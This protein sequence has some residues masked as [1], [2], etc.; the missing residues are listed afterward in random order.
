MPFLMEPEEAA[1]HM[2]RL[3]QS[4][5][6]KA[7]FPA[8]FSWFFRLGQFLPDWAYYRLFAPLRQEG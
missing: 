6:F 3:M 4:H 2:L 1:A 8:V 7:S 5:R